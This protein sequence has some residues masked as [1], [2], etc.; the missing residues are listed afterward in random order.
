MKYGWNINASDASDVYLLFDIMSG[1]C[2]L[3]YACLLWKK[4]GSI[5]EISIESQSNQSTQTN[6]LWYIVFCQNGNAQDRAEI[7]NLLKI[8]LMRIIFVILWKQLKR[9]FSRY[10][11]TFWLDIWK[12]WY[13]VIIFGCSFRI[14]SLKFLF[15]NFPIFA[16]LKAIKSP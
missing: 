2:H 7:K 6:L 5:C 10:E 13:F 15:F 8:S 3:K 11:S 1:K 9:T 16:C 4:S 12:S 14:T